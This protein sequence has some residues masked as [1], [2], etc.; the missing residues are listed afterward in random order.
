MTQSIHDISVIICAYTQ[1]RWDNLIEA[2]ESVLRQTLLPQEVIVVIDHCP[3]L[4]KRAQEQFPGVV[5]IENTGPQGLSGARNSGI[6]IAKGEVVAFL[7]D[8]A[9]ATADWLWSLTASFADPHV[10]GAGGPVIP[11]WTNEE[12]TW[13]PEEFHWVVGCT[14]RGMPET[15]ATIRNPV[16]ANMAFRRSVFDTAGGFRSEIGRVGTRPIG[17]EETE[18]CI[19]A[20]LRHPQGVF[21]YQPQASVLH[22]VPAKRVNLRYF[23]SRCYAEGLS[24]AAVT[25]YVGRKDGL[26]SERSYTL[27]TLPTGILCG[28]GDFLFQ[29]HPGGLARAG[30]IVGGLAV[31]TLGYLVGKIHLQVF[32]GRD[33]V[34]RKSSFL[35]SASLPFQKKTVDYAPRKEEVLSAD[36]F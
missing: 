17:C 18:L 9:V 22:H 16:G 6:C 5:V 14:Y 26:A 36:R 29:S 21:V 15:Q 28:V 35:R 25:R 8:D 24:K 11:L 2:V 27:R 23:W 12:P 19:R 4:R 13:F 33:G 31:T 1:E 34:S 30:L 10:L 32:S 20:R 3:E 7:D